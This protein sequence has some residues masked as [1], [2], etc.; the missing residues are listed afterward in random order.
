MN[1]L[2]SFLELRLFGVCTYLGEKLRM[3]ASKIKLFFIYLSF[4]TAGS[5]ILIYMSL[6]FVLRLKDYIKGKRNPIWDQ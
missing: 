1:S 2:K 6:A 4:I 5:P 3:P